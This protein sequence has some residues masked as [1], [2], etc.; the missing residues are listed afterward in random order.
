MSPRTAKLGGAYP[1]KSVY[2]LD[3]I[4]HEATNEGMING[5]ANT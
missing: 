5:P 1:P 2:D 3:V 4:R